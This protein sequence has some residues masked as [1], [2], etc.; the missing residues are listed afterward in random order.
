MQH[1]LILGGT[2]EAAALAA[3]ALARFGDRLRVTTA[4][5]GRTTHPGPIPGAVRIGGF[6]GASGLAA[7]LF[8]HGID[9]MIDAT[10][11]FAAVI[12]R[13]AREA[14]ERAGVPRL[15]LRRPPWRRHPLDRWIEVGSLDAAATL[16]GRLGTRAFL[17]IGAGGLEKFARAEGV[18]FFVRLIDP[19]PRALPLPQHEIVLGRGPFALAEERLLLRRHRIDVLVCKASGGAA[20]EAKL[21]AA[22]EL[23]LPVI[24]VRRPR[25][26]PG[27]AVET[28]EAALL[29][30]AGLDLPAQRRTL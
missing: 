12:S 15:V 13:A 2:G 4:L 5:A 1:L 19:P 21:I 9:C 27:P 18:H 20:T 10:H 26:E 30:L 24:M 23:A 14:A 28:V 29:W 25:P 22:R 8:E 3:A 16:V 6:G 11:P 7:Y 17:A